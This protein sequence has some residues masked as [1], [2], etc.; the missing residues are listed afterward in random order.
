MYQTIT[1]PTGCYPRTCVL[2]IGSFEPTK[3]QRRVASRYFFDP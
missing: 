3:S 2:D 1:P